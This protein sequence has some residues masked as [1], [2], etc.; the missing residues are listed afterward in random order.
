M[1]KK[2]TTITVTS[3]KIANPKLGE[4]QQIF[5]YLKEI[6]NLHDNSSGLFTQDTCCR[7]ST[8]TGSNVHKFL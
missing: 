5:V 1:M 7:R 4:G 6:L 2:A 3:G 8:T